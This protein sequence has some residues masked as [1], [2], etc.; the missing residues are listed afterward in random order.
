[1]LLNALDDPDKLNTWLLNGGDGTLSSFLT[2]SV[3]K[4]P[5]QYIELIE[6]F[7]FYYESGNYIFVH[8]AL[9]M[10]LADP[11]GDLETML[12]SRSQADLLDHRWLG[13]RVLIHGHTPTPQEEIARNFQDSYPIK[14]IDNGV[15]VQKPGYGGLCILES[16]HQDQC[17]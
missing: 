7:L 16:L 12:C 6:S 8:A 17:L 10:R 5:L 14:C 15:F 2:S 3:G 4:I 1:M 9:D 13:D 11:F